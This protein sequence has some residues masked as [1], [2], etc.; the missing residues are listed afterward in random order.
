MKLS[1]WLTRFS[2]VVVVLTAAIGGY[3]C[4][5]GDC[6]KNEVPGEMIL[7]PAGVFWMGC[8]SEIDNICYDSEN[9]ITKCN[10]PRITL[11]RRK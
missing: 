7:I 3:S 5:S 4:Q 2:L 10:C 8:N 1:I 11:T 6:V 9:H